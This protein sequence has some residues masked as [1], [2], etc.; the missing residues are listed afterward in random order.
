MI[1]LFPAPYLISQAIQDYQQSLPHNKRH[2]G[3]KKVVVQSMDLSVSSEPHVQQADLNR[4][5]SVGEEI[6]LRLGG[7]KEKSSDY[8]QQTDN[9]TD[10]WMQHQFHHVHL[11]MS[12][13][14]RQSWKV[15][16]ASTNV[17][18]S[19]ESS[20][21]TIE[22]EQDELFLASILRSLF[23]SLP[24]MKEFATSEEGKRISQLIR[25][26]YFHHPHKPPSSTGDEATQLRGDNVHL[27][28][29]DL[30]PLLVTQ[31]ITSL[32]T[33]LPVTEPSDEEEDDI[34]PKETGRI[35]NLYAYT[36]ATASYLFENYIEPWDFL[37][38]L[39]LLSAKVASKYLLIATDTIG[40]IVRASALDPMLGVDDSNLVVQ[41]KLKDIGLK[42]GIGGDNTNAS[43]ST[44]EHTS[45]ES[46]PSAE[47]DDGSSSQQNNN[48][49]DSISANSRPTNGKVSNKVKSK[50]TL[51]GVRGTEEDEL[52][53]LVPSSRGVN[54]L[55]ALFNHESTAF[56][57]DDVSCRG[58]ASIHANVIQR[59]M[60]ESPHDSIL[61]SVLSSVQ[62]NS[63]T[64]LDQQ[65]LVQG[66]SRLGL[67]V[68]PLSQLE[69]S[70]ASIAAS[71]PPP[72]TVAQQ[73]TADVDAQP[74]R[75]WTQFMGKLT[76]QCLQFSF[77]QFR[78]S[79]LF[80]HDLLA[81]V[82]GVDHPSRRRKL[83][84]NE[85]Q[86]NDKQN[87]DQT[88]TTIKKIKKIE[89]IN[90]V[91]VTVVSNAEEVP[92]RLYMLT[93]RFPDCHIALVL[94]SNFSQPIDSYTQTML[95]TSIMQYC[96]NC[97]E[98]SGD[99]RKIVL[100]NPQEVVDKLWNAFPV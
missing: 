12:D 31:L 32:L 89:V 27:H 83:L 77:H 54:R 70:L 5:F 40:S 6:K 62:I 81:D 7:F 9:Q 56:H 72:P 64:V 22:D 98:V 3:V 30:R 76:W 24:L 69:S 23:P 8:I 71:I 21:V 2:T 49:N 39:S 52:I 35:N 11:S 1:F 84:L 60:V 29:L 73:A 68:S 44:K 97:R 36:S 92:Y 90:H 57:Y 19:P 48:G 13:V 26:A 42:T 74:K 4:N 88:N 94:S 91:I 100:V 78:T 41:E 61:S 46:T 53:G 43:Q 63:G 86:Q 37:W 67:A 96:G 10:V 16:T 80:I 87:Q 20:N 15:P 95:K 51:R 79:C 59:A 14:L 55:S 28:L 66:L 38:D 75:T 82:S 47:K 85:E 45:Q 25:S 33:T 17:V 34:G 65:Y 18:G 58:S 99:G 93:Q 50:V